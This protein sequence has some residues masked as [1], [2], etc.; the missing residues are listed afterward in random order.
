MKTNFF[1]EQQ[2]FT[3]L[4]LWCLLIA[5]FLLPCLTPL[6][7]DNDID[8]LNDDSKVVLVL[9]LFFCFFLFVRT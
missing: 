2:K 3:Q 9:G 1:K 8:F 7:T 4:W 5:S 6:L